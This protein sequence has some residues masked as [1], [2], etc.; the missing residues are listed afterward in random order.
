MNV[1]VS[2]IRLFAARK[3]LAYQRKPTV[4]LIALIE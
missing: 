2:R 4:Y 1:F 3:P